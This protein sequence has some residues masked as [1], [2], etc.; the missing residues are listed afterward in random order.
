MILHNQKKLQVYYCVSEDHSLKMYNY[1][2]YTQGL[3][4]DPA[5]LIFFEVLLITQ[6]YVTL[7]NKKEI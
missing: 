5:K 7:N 4:K 6:V 2:H 3:L 1:T